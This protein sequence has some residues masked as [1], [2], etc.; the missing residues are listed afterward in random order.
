M[1]TY[2]PVREMMKGEKLVWQ[3]AFDEVRLRGTA[4]MRQKSCETVISSFFGLNSRKNPAFS[5]REFAG[6]KFG[7]EL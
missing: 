6:P 7:L 1:L 4:R 3:K 5:I 2:L